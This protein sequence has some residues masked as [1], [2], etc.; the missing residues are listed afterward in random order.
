MYSLRFLLFAFGAGVGVG[1]L[2]E[3][4]GNLMKHRHD[5]E[6]RKQQEQLNREGTTP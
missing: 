5:D 2:F 1:M 4:L 3:R 6:Q